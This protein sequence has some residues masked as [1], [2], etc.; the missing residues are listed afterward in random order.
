M[1][2]ELPAIARIA[3]ALVAAILIAFIATPVVKSLAEKVGAVDVPK[4]NRRMH[5][6]PIPR[7]GGLAIFLG[8]LLSTLIFVPLSNAMQGMLLGSV[9]IVI[10]G[11][12]DDIYALPALPKL[13]VQIAAALAAVLH[14]NVIQVISNPNIFSDNPYWV[15]G[16]WAVPVSVIWI[17]AITNAVN[18]IDGLDGLAV[19]VATISS[20]TMLV[21]A[22]LVSDSLVAL[23]MAALAGSCIGFL[24]YNHNP[25]KIFMGDTGSTFLGFV[26]AT[27]SIQGLFKFYTIISFAVPFLMLGLPLFDTCFAILRRLSKGQNPM[28]PDRSHVHHRLIDMGFSQKQAVAIL[29]VISAILGLSAVVL[30][31]SGALKAMVLLCALCLAGLIA[32]RISLSHGGEKTKIEEETTH[33]TESD[34]N[35]RDPSGGSEDGPSGEGAGEPGGN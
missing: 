25:A 7:M 18:L 22:M 6:H 26:L 3:A 35:L 1:T 16:A 5:N 20:L 17:V 30:T 4:D 29:Y 28:A 31:T 11:I 34:D 21:I 2:M 10:L 13:V 9:I 27:V 32:A 19:G 14:G 12:F 15:L 8:F 33:G 23:M 24:P